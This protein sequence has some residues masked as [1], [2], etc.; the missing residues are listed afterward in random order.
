MKNSLLK[1]KALSSFLRDVTFKAQVSVNYYI[2]K[3]SKDLSNDI[4]KQNFWYFVYRVVYKKLSVE[5]LQKQYFKMPSLADTWN[6]LNNREG[7]KLTVAINAFPAAKVSAVK[8]LV[9]QF[10]LDEVFSSQPTTVEVPD[11]ILPPTEQDDKHKIQSLIANLTLEIRNRLPSFPILAAAKEYGSKTVMTNR[12]SEIS[13]QQE[14]DIEFSA[15]DIFSESF[16]TFYQT[17]VYFNK[18]EVPVTRSWFQ[19]AV[20]TVTETAESVS[21]VIIG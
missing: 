4:F 13:I 12:Y 15:L 8:Y 10:I 1:I 19:R 2:L 17:K 21:H 16:E 7:V 14:F 20:S 3:H 11:D 5:D 18:V 9:Y 6:E